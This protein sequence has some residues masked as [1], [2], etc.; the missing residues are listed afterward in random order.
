[1][2]S[3]SLQTLNKRCPIEYYEEDDSLLI[4]IHLRD[5]NGRL[6][7]VIEYETNS[8]GFLH[9]EQVIYYT[10]LAWLEALG[11]DD[12]NDSLKRLRKSMPKEG[13]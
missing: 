1:M 5:K 3:H 4:R 9:P 6:V 12:W 10:G 8:D 11:N 2:N 13:W 7:D